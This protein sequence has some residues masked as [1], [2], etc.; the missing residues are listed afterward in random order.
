VLATVPDAVASETASV[1]YLL[2]LGLAALQR[3][4]FGAGHSVA[5]VGMGV[6]G[7][8]SVMVARAFGAP[9]SV[10]TRRETGRALAQRLGA[11]IAEPGR[12]TADIV[13]DTSNAWDDFRAATLLA[14]KGGTV[15][16][17]GFP[18][19]G[20]PPPEF[21]PF[22]P[23]I[24]YARQLAIIHGGETPDVDTPVEALRF[25]LARNM[26]HL[27]ALIAEGRLPAQILVTR[28]EPASRL[29]DAYAALLD[30]RGDALTVALDW[31][32]GAGA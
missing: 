17:L 9:T 20:L 16:L 26:R 24:T 6:L 14:R 7:A 23:A 28:H 30:A 15:V 2:Q 8:A 29:A 12:V 32:G 27:I 25:N 21:N 11:A 10:L 4:G 22:D 5:V 19:R 13:I 3:A 1:A 18:G 31:R